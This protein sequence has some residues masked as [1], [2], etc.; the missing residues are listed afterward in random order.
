MSGTEFILKKGVEMMEE[1][2]AS[3]EKSSNIIIFSWM[4]A[5][6]EVYQSTYISESNLLSSKS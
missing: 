1:E 2:D 5:T 6:H 3:N 4:K